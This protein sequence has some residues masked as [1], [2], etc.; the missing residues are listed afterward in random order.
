MTDNPKAG[1]L[2]LIRSGRLAVGTT[3]YHPARRH[4]ERGVEAVVEV[5]G[6]RIGNKVYTSPSA[7]AEAI[8][9][10]PVNGWIFWRIRSTREQ[11]TNLRA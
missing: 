10:G 5:G 9:G 7:A 8:T 1:L 2:D 4:R 3:L 11:I 6:I